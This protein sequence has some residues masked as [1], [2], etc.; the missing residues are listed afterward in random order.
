MKLVALPLAVLLLAGCAQSTVR[1]TYVATTAPLPK[2]FYIQPFDI[3]GTELTGWMHPSTGERPLRKAIAPLEFA[4][5]LRYELAKVAPTAV[6][7]PGQKAP[8]GWVVSGSFDV[9]D[10]GKPALRALPVLGCL[11][12]GGSK[13]VAH[14]KMT[15]AKTGQVIHA[16]DVS[17]GSGGTAR[18]GNTGAPGYGN[19][20]NHDMKNAAERI[21]LAISSD[22][23]RYGLRANP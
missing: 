19:A 4:E 9:V 6:L 7:E 8:E 16:F 17:G 10:A 3:A 18:L 15:D 12:V 1:K 22:P 20:L 14:V 5:A 11:G 21:M 23:M 2:A 13:F